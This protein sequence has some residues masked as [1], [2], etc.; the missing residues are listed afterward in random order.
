MTTRRFG[1]G[2]ASRSS[3]DP[4]IMPRT[5]PSSKAF[6]FT[7]TFV[8][9]S[10]PQA[11]NISHVCLAG[12]LV[13]NDWELIR[14]LRP[15]YLVTLMDRVDLVAQQNYLRGTQLLVLDCSESAKP[16]LD[17]LSWLKRVHRSL[18]ILLVDGGLSQQEIA[19]AF[20]NGVKDYFASPYDVEL[21]VE[22]IDALCTR[23]ASQEDSQ[24]I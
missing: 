24:T 20:G 4:G 18:C 5:L 1:A 13:S 14:R 11:R 3:G 2:I 12:R 9:A 17:C 15:R 8:R 7:A 21:L 22:R 19:A 16:V 10:V 23:L 6:L